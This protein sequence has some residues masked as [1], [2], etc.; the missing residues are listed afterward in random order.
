MKIILPLIIFITFFFSAALS[1]VSNHGPVIKASYSPFGYG[2]Y[3]VPHDNAINGGE[4]GYTS[5]SSNGDGFSLSTLN[6]YSF[7]CGYFYDWFQGDINYTSMKTADQYVEKAS[8]SGS[9]LYADASFWSVD[10]KGG[11]RFSNQGDTSYKWLYLGIKKMNLE[12]PYN[13]TEADAIGF[14]AGFYGF[15]SFGISYPFEFVLTYEI[16]GGSY[17][18]VNNNLNTD[19]NINIEKKTAFDL[20]LSAGVGMQYEPWD[21]AVILKVT[22]FIS[23]K[24]YKGNDTGE[25]KKTNAGLRG[26][27]IGIEI[28]FTIPEYKNNTLD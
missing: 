15:S 21:L 24:I 9:K 3:Q 12:I 27:L 20:G 10:F 6:G 5:G 1:A 18:Y 16:Y 19:V 17:R 2:I 14:L 22:P 4:S 25:N 11:Y 8:T 28:I 13:H 23:Q 26:G 7:S